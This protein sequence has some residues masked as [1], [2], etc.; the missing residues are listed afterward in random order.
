MGVERETE[1]VQA[2]ERMYRNARIIAAQR[3]LAEARLKAIRSY[4]PWITDDRDADAIR[5]LLDAEIPEGTS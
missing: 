3:D 4:L 1:L 2:S 5:T